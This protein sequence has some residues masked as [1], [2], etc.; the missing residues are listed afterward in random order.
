MKIASKKTNK[1][2]IV[3]IAIIVATL[4]IGSAAFAVY[5]SQNSDRDN[6]QNDTQNTEVNLDTPTDQQ[7][8]NGTDIKQQNVEDEATNT[9]ASTLNVSLNVYAKNSSTTHVTVDIQTLISAGTCTLTVSNGSVSKSYTAE[10]QPLA[11]Y[12]TCKGFDIPNDEIGAGNW[13]I[14]VSVQSNE[15]LTGNAT[16]SITVN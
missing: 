10:V 3:T 13:G 6:A 1:L 16:G 11:Q 12:S 15:G 9:P 4:L 8:D 5:N 7:T 14:S 2:P